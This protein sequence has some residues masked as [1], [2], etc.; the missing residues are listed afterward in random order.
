MKVARAEACTISR[1]LSQPVCEVPENAGEDISVGT[2]RLIAR[3]RY[4]ELHLRGH[5]P[6]G[7]RVLDDLVCCHLQAHTPFLSPQVLHHGQAQECNPSLLVH[8]MPHV[9]MR[10]ASA[11]CQ[12]CQIRV[13]AMVDHY[14]ATMAVH[15]GREMQRTKGL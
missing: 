3:V 9:L 7:P 15:W 8:L 12:I 6:R 14:E 11:A 4:L 10:I 1:D 13:L 5:L 2:H